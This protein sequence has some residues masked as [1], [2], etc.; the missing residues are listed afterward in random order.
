MLAL[1][2]Y[3]CTLYPFSRGHKRCYACAYTFAY[4]TLCLCSPRSKSEALLVLLS[5]IS[6]DFQWKHGQGCIK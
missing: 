5:G 3:I 1:N 6:F 4:C 2:A